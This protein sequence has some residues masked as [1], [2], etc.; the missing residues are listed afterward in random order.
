MRHSLPE[1]NLKIQLISIRWPHT[2][3]P[4]HLR[5]NSQAERY[6][7][8]FKRAL[9]KNHG[10]DTDERSIHKIFISAQKH[11]KHKHSF[12]HVTNQTN[13]GLHVECWCIINPKIIISQ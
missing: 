6:V 3:S 11:S 7:D 2:T 9:R 1:G 12:R 5:P 8:S 13:V 4:Y 10:L